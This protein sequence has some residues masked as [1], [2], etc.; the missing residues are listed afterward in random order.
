[1]FK[2]SSDKIFYDLEIKLIEEIIGYEDVDII[3]CS[4]TFGLE[5]DSD[6]FYKNQEIIET[7]MKDTNVSRDRKDKLLENILYVN[8][9]N[10]MKKTL[11]K[12]RLIAM[13]VINY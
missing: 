1:M 2:S 4:N 8:L 12:Y 7:I 13:V 10:K 3:F 11:M 5:E 6:E 9:V